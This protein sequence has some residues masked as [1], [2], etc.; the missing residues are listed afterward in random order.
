MFTYVVVLAMFGSEMLVWRTV[1][2]KESLFPFVNAGV[3]IVWMGG[4]RGW[5]LG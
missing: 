2:A 5:Y 3:G 4:M 1:A